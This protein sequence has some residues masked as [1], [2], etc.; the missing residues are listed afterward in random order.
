MTG[1]L[2]LSHATVDKPEAQALRRTLEDSGVAVWEDV[3]GLR[4]GDGLSDLEREVKGARPAPALDPGGERVRMGRARGWMGA[5]GPGG[6]PRVPD[7]G[8]AARR[9]PDFG[10]ASPG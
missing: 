10:P 7:P 5:A 4:A 2:F 3:L 9:R 6:E 8:R 1:K